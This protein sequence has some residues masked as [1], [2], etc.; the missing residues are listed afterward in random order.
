MR[1]VRHQTLLLLE[2]SMYKVTVTYIILIS[3]LKPAKRCWWKTG[4][5]VE[6]RPK[7]SRSTSKWSLF[8]Q[9]LRGMYG[10]YT[11]RIRIWSKDG[12]LSTRSGVNEFLIVFLIYLNLKCCVCWFDLSRR[13]FDCIFSYFSNFECILYSN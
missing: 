12:L 9:C 13:M 1:V 4:N 10:R 2:F 6:F 7:S 8:V 3:A 11:L 5:T